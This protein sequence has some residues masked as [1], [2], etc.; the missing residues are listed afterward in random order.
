MH[1]AKLIAVSDKSGHTIPI[2]KEIFHRCGRTHFRIAPAGEPLG[3]DEQPAVFLLCDSEPHAEAKEFARLVAEY[4]SAREAIPPEHRPV[5]YSVRSD[6][7]DFTARGLRLTG[8]GQIAFEI[9]GVGVIGRVRLLTD[10]EFWAEPALAAAAAS[11]AAGVPFADA[12][13]A[14]NN[15]EFK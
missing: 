9:V 1:S 11:I 4:E 6:G 13:E 14:L 3:A 12:L 8:E 10:R 5:T 7:A 15:M 2:L